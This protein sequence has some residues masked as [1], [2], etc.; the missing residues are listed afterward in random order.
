MAASTEDQSQPFLR[1]CLSTG[2]GISLKKKIGE[3]KQTFT[4]VTKQNLGH[5]N[6]LRF[7]L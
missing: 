2:L 5:L 4:I 7:I 6:Y 3:A 1:S